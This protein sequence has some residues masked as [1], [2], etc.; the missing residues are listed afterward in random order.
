MF[1]A[2]DVSLFAETKVT[3]FDMAPIVDEYIIRLQ[4]PMDI[5]HLMHWLNGQN[6]Q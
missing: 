4:I 5:T 1:N 6:L 3:K 2:P